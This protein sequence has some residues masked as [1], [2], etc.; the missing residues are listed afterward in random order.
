MKAPTIRKAFERQRSATPVGDSPC[1]VQQHDVPT[2]NINNI[3]DKY[4]KTGLLEHVNQFRGN[5]GDFTSA[6][7]YHEAFNKLVEAQEMFM[8][9]PANV[10]DKFANDPGLFLEYVSDENNQAG[11][12]ELGLLPKKAPAKP[13][14]PAK[15]APKSEE[16]SGSKAPEPSNAM[17]DKGGSEAS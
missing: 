12:E 14:E 3:M 15:E 2:C 8:T 16:G 17:K 1:H 13:Q 4:R 6:P 7:T 10:R 11:M 9:L 5:Y